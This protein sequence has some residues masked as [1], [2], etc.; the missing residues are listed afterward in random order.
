MVVAILGIMSA[1]GVQSGWFSS[2]QPLE[3]KDEPALLF[4]NKDQG[5]PCVQVVYENADL[6]IS[7]WPSADRQGVP[8]KRISLDERPDLGKQYDVNR[9]P[10]LLLFDSQGDEVWRQYATITSEQVFDLK[11]FEEKI[12]DLL[13]TP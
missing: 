2:R 3:L 8:V 4:F 13:D 5:C 7:R 12:I 9:S 10:A 11:L 6:Q 1:K